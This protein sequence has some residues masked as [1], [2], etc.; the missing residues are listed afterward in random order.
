M[1][2]TR[3][4]LLVTITAAVAL[5]GC[6]PSPEA[7]SLTGSSTIAPVMMEISE[8]YSAEHH[9]R[10]DVQSG[11]SGRGIQDVR[12]GLADAGMASRALTSEELAEGL[13][14]HTIAWDGIALILHRD[15]P[16]SELSRDQ[17]IALYRG[18]I[19]NW[20][21]LLPHDAPVVV[22]NKAEGRSTLDLFLQEF[23]LEPSQIKADVVAGENQ[24]VILTVAGNPGAIGYVSIGA[25]LSAEAAGTAIRTLPL[26]G[27]PATTESIATGSWPLQRPLNLV[28]G[29][30][31]AEAVLKLIDYIR[32]DNHARNLI[33]EYQFIPTDG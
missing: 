33:L 27:I 21:T 4:G 25:A 5:V 31:P 1:L 18:E 28:T 17:I 16:A 13:L 3:S 9:V 2:A 15:N 14:A 30:Q 7:L 11:G 19:E 8:R 29:A 6:A 32:N 20:S 26:D 22:V 24:Q 23:G 10:I 12:L